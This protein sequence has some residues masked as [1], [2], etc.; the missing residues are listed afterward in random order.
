MGG[1]PVLADDDVVAVVD[2]K[3]DG[4]CCADETLGVAATL[5]FVSQGFRGVAIIA[6]WVES[7]TCYILI[8][9]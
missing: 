5:A 3:P 8:S 6:D 4:C 2:L 9:N 7:E 1:A